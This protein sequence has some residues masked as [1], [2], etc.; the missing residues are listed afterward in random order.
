MIRGSLRLE[1][2]SSCPAQG[3]KPESRACKCD[4]R[5]RARLAGQDYTLGSLEK[6]WRVA[7]LED[8]ERKL[9][10]M[11][12]AIAD[13]RS[14][15]PR[16]VVTLGEFALGWFQALHA[17]AQ[18]GQISPLTFNKYE[19]DW[20]RHVGPWF[21]KYP[22]GAIDAALINRY[23]SAK[24]EAGYSRNAVMS[25]LT[26]LS[27]M[28]T[29]AAAESPPLIVANPMRSPK[30]GRHGNRRI[31][32]QI[33]FEHKA[34]KHLEVDQAVALLEL[35]ADEYFDLVLCPLVT[36]FRRMEIA[37]LEWDEILWG[38]E[39]V[40]LTGQLRTK[41]GGG[42]VKV[43]AKYDSARAVPL[44][45]GFAHA[46]GRRRQAEGYVFVTQEGGPFSETR[47]KDVLDELYVEA[48]LKKPLEVRREERAARKKKG[49]AGV[50]REHGL[51]WHALRHTYNSVLAA[52]GVP[53]HVREELLGHKRHDVTGRY[54]HVLSGAYAQVD[55]VL[56]EAFG[57]VV[58]RRLGTVAADVERVAVD[59]NAGPAL[60]PVDRVPMDTD[61]NSPTSEF[62]GFR[63]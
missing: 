5:V 36:G 23:I 9:V 7:D 34:P 32:V 40:D 59:A 3:H 15:R 29:D 2:K 61:K 63:L 8:F 25:Q 38:K 22:L 33:E 21:G 43:K 31:G 41:K 60:A 53:R 47:I 51:G 46:L 62:R 1:H 35:V 55:Q 50:S 48:G 27:G 10:D 57:D 13:G 56:E 26:V 28:L 37:G 17:S 24:L 16:K 42:L 49:W 6:G 44:Y 11:R 14:P 45:S 12:E 54:E 58:R 20:R 18:L 19:G 52:G 4:P 30:R 39:L